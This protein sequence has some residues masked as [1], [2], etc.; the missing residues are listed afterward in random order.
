MGNKCIPK[1]FEVFLWFLEELDTPQ[2]TRISVY[3]K[4]FWQ[5]LTVVDNPSKTG[6]NVYYKGFNVF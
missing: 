4:D 1:V 6:Y 5:F 2:K 3:S